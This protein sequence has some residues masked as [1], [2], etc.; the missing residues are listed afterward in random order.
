VVTGLTAQDLV[1]VAHAG[2]DCAITYANL[3]DG[4]TIEQAPAAVA[5]ANTDTIWVAQGSN[6]MARQ[7]FGAVWAWIASQLP[8]YSV[9]VVEITASTSLNAS[10]H[11][12]RILICSQ[13][14][15]LTPA[16]A[17]MGSGFQCTI[18]NASTGIVTL[19]TGFVSSTGGLTL[20]PEQ[21]ASICCVTYSGGTIA[22]ASLAGT[23]TAV[24]PGQVSSLSDLSTTSTTVTLSWQAPTSGGSASS[25]AVQYRISGTSAWT[26][27]ATVIGATTCSLAGL[28]A[29]TSYD[30]IVQ[31]VNT[32][33]TGLS[34]S[35]LTVTTAAAT[36]TQAPVPP[37]VTGL[38]VAPVSSSAVQ[39]TWSAQTGTGAATSFT[40]QYRVTGS[41]TW[42][43]SV[44]GVSG[45]TTT[46]SGLQA[47]TSYDFSI[48]GVDSSGSGPLSATVTAVTEAATVG[49]SVSSI[50]WNLLP[51]GPYT[52]ASGAIGVNAHVT[53]STAP[54]QFGFSLSS[55]TL[56]SSWTA[57]VLVNT[58]LWGAYA[59]TPTAAGTWFVWAEGIDGSCPTVSTTSFLVQ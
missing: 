1:A 37:Q 44:P 40:I 49:T 14:V 19:G 47:A 12:G 30:V 39:V 27:G 55:T 24:A 25:Y 28:A 41:T 26:S 16:T 54:I 46:I 51:S 3:L 42:T 34:S 38:V 29:S 50:T 5:A 35:I 57:A 45:T 22:F 58:N 56:P 20:A 21:T 23:A 36:S 10:A 4:M 9:P 6:V 15:T 7:T 59:P 43:S 13:S 2:T 17:K 18:I 33:G 53:P 8:T 31:A 11:N 52:H 32:A 48:I